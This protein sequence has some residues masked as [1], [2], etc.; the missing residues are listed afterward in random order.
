MLSPASEEVA[1]FFAA[2]L[3]SDHAKNPTFIDNFFE[4]FRQ[5]L[6]ENEGKVT[7]LLIQNCPIKSFE[8]C[9]FTPILDHLNKQ[10]ELRK[11]MTK[12]EKKKIKD[13]KQ[14]I[15]D[16]YGWCI[17]DD[18]KEKVGNFRIEPPGLFRG[19]GD[20]PRTGC[21]KVTRKFIG[22]KSTS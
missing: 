16:E 21:L 8:K 4:D 2:L 22:A 19:R 7:G 12:E 10:K 13:E 15:D 11:Q 3:E 5:V 20:H 1:T 14:L 17:M 9:D 6:V 18:R